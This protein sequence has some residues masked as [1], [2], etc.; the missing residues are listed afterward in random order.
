MPGRGVITQRAMDTT[1]V[2]EKLSVVSHE[3]LGDLGRSLT[4]RRVKKSG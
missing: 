4:T 1:N 3:T 2:T